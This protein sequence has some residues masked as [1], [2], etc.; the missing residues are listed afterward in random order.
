MY[1]IVRIT[2]MNNRAWK[3]LESPYPTIAEL[4][5]MSYDGFIDYRLQDSPITKQM[6][7]RDLVYSKEDLNTNITTYLSSYTDPLPKESVIRNIL[8]PKFMRYIDFWNYGYDAKRGDI[9]LGHGTYNP[10]GFYEDLFITNK[11]SSKTPAENINNL[12]YLVNGKVVFPEVD[13]DNVYLR[14]VFFRLNKKDR[15]GMGIIDFSD[16]G[17]FTKEILNTSMIS[18]A[19]SNKIYSVINIV[20]N[21]KFMDYYLPESD[22]KIIE[23]SKL[24]S[25]QYWVNVNGTKVHLNTFGLL[26]EAKKDV[27]I[28]D[29]TLVVTKEDLLRLY[30]KISKAV[31]IIVGGLLYPLEKG[32]SIGDDGL[33]QVRIEHKKIIGFADDPILERDWIYP[34]NERYLGFDMNSLDIEKYLTRGDSAILTIDN[35]RVAVNEEFLQTSGFNNEYLHYRAPQGILYQCDGSIGEYVVSDWDYDLVSLSVTPPRMIDNISNTIHS[36]QITNMHNINTPQVKTRR[37]AKMIDYYF[38]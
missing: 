11:T 2:V 4:M 25:G 36:T 38:L 12:L 26:E 6:K 5:A 22:S 8:R 7:I 1:V 9:A 31:F 20:P 33:I 29:N 27:Y 21:I 32:Y 34:A 15:K 24:L 37:S 30:K 18:I 23:N 16:M 14:K 28:D 10:N 3:V 35:D 19:E 13:G 17:G